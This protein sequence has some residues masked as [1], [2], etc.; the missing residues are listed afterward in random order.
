MFANRTVSRKR[1]AWRNACQGRGAWV[2]M[3]YSNAYE[4]R[5]W[6]VCAKKKNTVVSRRDDQPQD[7]ISGGEAGVAKAVVSGIGSLRVTRVQTDKRADKQMCMS[8]AGC[9]TEMRVGAVLE[10]GKYG[11]GTGRGE[12][13]DREEN[14]R[15]NK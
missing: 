5:V 1:W 15:R 6:S 3:C 12:N 7:L 9:K 14:K 13:M 11:Q 2:R 4:G 8:G 10:N